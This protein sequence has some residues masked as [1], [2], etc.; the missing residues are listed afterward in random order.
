MATVKLKRL[1]DL[2]KSKLRRLPA[3]IVQ[4]ENLIDL[5]LY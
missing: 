4:S 1:L 3:E 2:E 5:F